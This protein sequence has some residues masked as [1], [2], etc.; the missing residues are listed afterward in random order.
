MASTTSPTPV[1]GAPLLG[2]TE[3]ALNAILGRELA[4]TGLTEPQWV[5]L[6][7]AITAG[8][9][10]GREALVGRVARGLRVDEGEA[11]DRVDELTAARLLGD[12]GARKVKPTDAGLELHARIRTVVAEITA[13]IWGDLPADDLM[14]AAAVLGTV[15]DRADA[16]LERE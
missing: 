3:K 10:V 4:G 13:R 12:A 14:T 16:E 6:T 2:Q 1:F 11:A 7:L 15:L 5:T 9:A 8:R